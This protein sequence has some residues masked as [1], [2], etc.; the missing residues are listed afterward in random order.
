MAEGAGTTTYLTGAL[1]RAHRACPA[2]AWALRHRPEIVPPDPEPTLRR[3]ADTRRVALVARRRHPAGV[4]IAPDDPLAA[5]RATAAAV[6][7]GATMIFD[8]AVVTASGLHARAD[9][10][11]READ[12]WA[13]VVVDAG[14][15]PSAE[16]RHDAAFRLIA[17]AEAGYRLTRVAIQ[18]LDRR[19]RRN[20]R[21]DLDG[22]FAETSVDDWC[23][24]HRAEIE[25]EIAAARRTLAMPDCPP[26]TCDRATRARRCPTFDRFHPGFPTGG[27]V[28][29]LVSINQQRLAEALDRGVRRLVDWPADL[30][31][32]A[33]QR[34]QVE[35]A[36]SGRERV[37]Q[38]RLRAFVEAVRYPCHFVDYETFQT[39]VPLFPGT[40]PWQQVPFQYSLHVLHEDGRL[41]HREFLWTDAGAPPAVP[42]AE[43]LRRDIG[44]DGSVLV[45]WKG[46]EGS[47]NL[48]LAETAPHLAGFLHGLNARMV[49]LMEP[50][51]RGLWVHP[52]FGGSTSIKKVLPVVAPELS[53]DGLEIGHGAVATLRWKQCVVD[54]APP[55]GIDPTAAFA[56]LRAYCRHDTLGMVRIWQH[57]RDLAGVG[58]PEPALAGVAS[59][60]LPG[61]HLPAQGRP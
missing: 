55:D 31:L 56:Q 14:T 36:R 32:S 29:D 6:A 1:L 26:C 21:L 47:R 45:W 13:L 12:G 34:W 10:L 38:D 59:G 50:V 39:P 5:A 48:E 52:A 3:E 60:P 46:F 37:K 42:L 11:V 18:H 53:Y 4:A 43:A 25:I 57:Y 54:E 41:E 17:F 30:A 61:L 15:S 8:A 24:E 33:R 22:L 35:A 20:G 49:D 7:A 19:Y 28:F 2:W 44:D 16:R 40:W 51:S 58:A 27:T 23:R 9:L